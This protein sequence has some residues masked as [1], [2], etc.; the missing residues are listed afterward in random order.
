MAVILVIE[1][2]PQIRADIVQ[3]L[4]LS[5]HKLLSAGDGLDGIELAQ[6]KLPDLIVCDVSMPEL[7]GYSVLEKLSDSS[8]TDQIPFI[9]LTGYT[10]RHKMRH[11]MDLGADDYLVKPFTPDE[12]LSAVESH[13]AKQAKLK[14]REQERIEALTLNLA[15]SLPHE[16]NTPLN[17]IMGFASL[18]QEY[19]SSMDAEEIQDIAKNIKAS[20]E[21]LYRLTQNFLFYSH[22]ELQLAQHNSQES[23]DELAKTSLTTEVIQEVVNQATLK[24]DRQ[25]NIALELENVYVAM[26]GSDLG[27]LV[28]ELLDNALKFSP[29]EA[30]IIIRGYHQH[31]QWIFEIS[32]QGRGFTASQA[33]SISA[34][35]QFE[36]HLWE[37]QGAGLGL[38]IVDR[39][40]KLHEGQFQITN[41][42]QPTTVSI[43]LPCFTD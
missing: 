18:L 6:T 4:E 22:L 23:I 10:E 35:L 5:D 8:S 39:L 7:D 11:G 30:P 19:G 2:E 15:L 16:L 43:V 26:H 36:R 42:S 14:R 20:G 3:I 9:F 13:L 12:L 33:Q 38:A 41:L 31:Q 25:V 32:D 17:G 24:L 27:K 29:L 40:V 34:G 21:R 1:D 28:A 37:Q